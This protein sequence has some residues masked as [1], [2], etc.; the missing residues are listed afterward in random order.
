MCYNKAMDDEYLKDYI[1]KEAELEEPEQKE[2]VPEEAQPEEEKPKK[3][4]RLF[5]FSK[6]DEQDEPEQ[7]ETEPEEE[8]PEEEKPKKKKKRKFGFSNVLIILYLLAHIAYTAWMFTDNWVHA[9]LWLFVTIVELA[10]FSVIMKTQKKVYLL[11][12]FLSLIFILVLLFNTAFSAF[13]LFT[14]EDRNTDGADY[15]LVMGFGLEDNQMTE[16]L[17][18]RCDKAIEYMQKNPQSTAVLCGGITKGSNI[19]EAAAMKRYMQKAGIAER[20]LI[21]EDSS[22]NTETNISYAKKLITSGSKIVVV[23]SDYHIHRIRQVCRKAGLAVKGVPAN[24]PYLQLPDKLMWEKIKLI[25]LLMS[26]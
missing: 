13:M 6:D 17:T 20:R 8:Q 2:T 15:L 16:I 11:G 9:L 25:R 10:V 14:C 26:N 4:K 24:T 18:L 7:E 19:S 1:K 5:G 3:K 23:S 21:V 12:R 22:T